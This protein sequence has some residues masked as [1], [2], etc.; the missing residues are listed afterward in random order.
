MCVIWYISFSGSILDSCTFYLA[1]GCSAPPRPP[2]LEIHGRLNQPLGPHS[3]K[4]GV[5]G[6][7]GATP[8]EV[9]KSAA[10]AA[11]ELP[12]VMCCVTFTLYVASRREACRLTARRRGVG[13][14]G[15]RPPRGVGSAAQGHTLGSPSG[16]FFRTNFR[17]L[18]ESILVRSWLDFPSQLASQN[19]SKSRKN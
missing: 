3:N 8:Q 2:G 6:G 13:G 16:H 14:K 10:L 4:G 15:V 19:P 5:P 18:F 7:C 12:K 9:Q 11:C 1:R 17:C